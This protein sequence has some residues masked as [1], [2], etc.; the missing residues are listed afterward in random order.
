MFFQASLTF[1]ELLLQP[2]ELLVFLSETFRASAA[3]NHQGALTQIVF[4]WAKKVT[5]NIATT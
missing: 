3:L 5:A 2:G 4:C 1:A